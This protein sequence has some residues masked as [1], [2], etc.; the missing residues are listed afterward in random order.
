MTDAYV[1]TSLLEFTDRFEGQVF[2]R[3]TLDTCEKVYAGLGTIVVSGLEKPITAELVIVSA[4]DFDYKPGFR[5]AMP[6][7]PRLEPTP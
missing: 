4:G 5:W 3:G 6:K 2:Y 1:V 7:S